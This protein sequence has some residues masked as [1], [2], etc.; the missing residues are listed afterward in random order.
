MNST[1]S[2]FDPHPALGLLDSIVA[3][4][5]RLRGLIQ[6]QQLEFDP[7]DPRN[8]T[9]DGKFTARGVETLTLTDFADLSNPNNWSSI[10]RI[11][12]TRPPMAS[13]PPAASKSAIDSS[14]K[15]RLVTPSP[16]P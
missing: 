11:L 7:K 15:E 13:S 12:G 3:D 5:D 14:T 16:R 1:G 4:L 2:S 9:A 6:P 8:K 10:P